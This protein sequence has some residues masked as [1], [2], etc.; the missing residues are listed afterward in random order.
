MTPPEHPKELTPLP[1]S[2]GF[3]QVNNYLNSPSDTISDLSRSTGGGIELLSSP[4][5]ANDLGVPETPPQPAISRVD[6]VLFDEGYDTD[7][8]RP[9]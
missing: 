6:D 5:R 7:G 2:L 4:L 1:P 9:V 8:L 3:V